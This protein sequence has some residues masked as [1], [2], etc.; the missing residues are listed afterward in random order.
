MSDSKVMLIARYHRMP[1]N[2]DQMER[3]V[4]QLSILRS[5]DLAIASGW[6]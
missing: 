3:Q 2:E 6:I 1:G 4:Q 5:I